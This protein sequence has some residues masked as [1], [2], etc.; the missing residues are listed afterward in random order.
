MRY[1]LFALLATPLL[2]GAG[3]GAA[4]DT[5]APLVPGASIVKR[6]DARGPGGGAVLHSR[7]DDWTMRF[8]VAADLTYTE[9][10]SQDWTLLTE[11]GVAQ[12]TRD[13]VT[14]HPKSQSLTLVEAW[15]TQADGTRLTVPADAVFTRPS[16]AAQDAPGFTASETMTVV[17]PQLHPGSRTH[18]AWRLTQNTAPVNG[19]NVWLQ[20]PVEVS[21]RHIGLTLE[22]PVGLRLHT[23]FR[24]RFRDHTSAQGG[25]R[26]EQVSI[27]DTRALNPEPNAVASSDYQPMFLATSLPDEAAIGAIYARQSAAMARPTPEIAALAARIVGGK[28]GIDAAR[29]IYDWVAAD[30]RYVAVYL[31][32]NDGWVPHDASRVLRAGYG[33]CKDHVVLMQALL[34]SRGI[35]AQAA[36]VSYGEAYSPLPAWLPTQYNHAIIYL[37]QWRRFANPT[38]PFASFDASDRL[39]A[40][41]QAVLATEHGAVAMIPQRRS[42]DDTYRVDAIMDLA[43]DGTVTGH[44]ILALSASIDSASRRMVA[45]ALSPEDLAERLLADTP[46][47]GF[48]TVTGSDPRDLDTAFSMLAD[49]QSPH[50]VALHDGSGFAAIPTGIDIEQPA[51]LRGLLNPRRRP[52]HDFTAGALDFTWHIVWRLPAALAVTRLPRDVAL[53]NRTGRYEATYRAH[54]N[55]IE[56]TRHLSVLQDVYKPADYPAFEALIEAPIDD[57]REVVGFAPAE[58]RRASL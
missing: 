15:V 13:A 35:D 25:T 5:A 23:A 52:L 2:G 32:P 51:G 21:A 56:V 45:H 33:D 58:I 47:G 54:G 7:L 9:S 37:P 42:A 34:A 8:K 55:Q 40:G 36:L 19:F 30:I 6:S 22:T 44:A 17:F 18:V 29:A 4:P 11:R 46:E 39:L 26:L 38:D 57:A 10:F 43:E 53:A 48:G 3:L 49:W 1:F 24:G 41:K 28:T 27:G 50:A 12:N 20:V 16:A 31:N 14:F